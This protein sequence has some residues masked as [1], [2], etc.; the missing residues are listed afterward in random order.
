M[1]IMLTNTVGNISIIVAVGKKK[2]NVPSYIETIKHALSELNNEQKYPITYEIIFVTNDP[3]TIALEDVEVYPLSGSIRIYVEKE[4][5]GKAMLFTKGVVLA[6]HDIVIALDVG[7]QLPH[8]TL[9]DILSEIQNGTDV[10]AALQNEQTPGEKSN[11]FQQITNSFLLRVQKNPQ[12]GA[13]VFKKYVWETL[14]QTTFLDKTFAIEFLHK[15][16]EAGFSVIRYDIA[17]ENRV[18]LPRVRKV[19]RTINAAFLLLLMKLKKVRP[20]PTL[21]TEKGSQVNAGV[22]YKKQHYITHSTLSYKDS[23]IDSFTLNQVFFYLLCFELILLGFRYNII[24]LAQVIFACLSFIYLLDVVFNIFLVYKT[25]RG[26]SEI[27]FTKEELAQLPDSTLPIYTILCPL[28]KEAHMLAPFIEGIAKIEYPKDKLDVMLLLEE[29]DVASIQTIG[30]MHLPGY[31]RTLV[32]PASQPKTKPKACNYGLAFAR[33]EYV[34][35]FDAED[36]PDPMQLK[37]AYIGFQKSD[38]KVVCLQ[39]KLNYHNTNQNLL[40]RFFTAEYSWLFDV[41]LPGLQSLSTIIPLGGTSN[42][43]RTVDLNTLNGWDPFNVTEDADLGLRIFKKGYRTAIIDSVTLEEANSNVG[44]WIRQRSRWV[45]GYMQTYLVHT[46]ETLPFIRQ[47]G[48]QALMLHVVI[49]QRI[50]FIFVN[51]LLWIVTIAY[52]TFHGVFGTIIEQTYPPIILYTAVISL[53]FGNYLYILGYILGCVKRGQ[54]GLIKYVYFIPF[55]L[56][57]ISVAGCMA[58]YQLIFKPHYWE[59]TVHGLHLVQKKKKSSGGLKLPD[60]SLP[61]ITPERPALAD[62]LA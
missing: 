40:T 27:T 11:V 52:F 56:L 19:T 13:L 31:V 20:I 5:V 35:I 12:A 58:F 26:S 46:R 37:K 10:V 59:K 8:A 32:V 23:A 41:S 24:L 28:Y 6:K 17:H 44:N 49:G 4:H 1:S 29:D 16:N 7:L 43:F 47:R 60:F 57:L 61:T 45:K 22:R 62:K 55:Y 53:V 9:K 14:K 51:P 34:V 21:S 33:G 42:H 25:I 3:K 39:A 2:I 15:A 18:V 30:K 50:L 36:I 38:R 54:W 48:F